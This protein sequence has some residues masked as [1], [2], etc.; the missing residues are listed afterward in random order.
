MALRPTYFTHTSTN[1]ACNDEYQIVIESLFRVTMQ[2][3]ENPKERGYIH[4]T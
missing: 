1:M 2:R 3:L 4:D